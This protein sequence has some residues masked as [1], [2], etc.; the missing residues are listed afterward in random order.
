MK[1]YI[2]LIHDFLTKNTSSKQTVIKNTFWLLLAEGVS[3][4]STF[5][6]TFYVIN[7]FAISE[8]GMYSYA[9]SIWTIIAILFDYW[10]WT[11]VLRAWWDNMNVNRLLWSKT[12]FSIILFCI[13]TLI[14]IYYINIDFILAIT[15]YLSIIQFLFVSFFEFFKN[16]F[17]GIKIAYYDLT[18]RFLYSTIYL[19]LS[20]LFFYLNFPIYYIFIANILSC[21]VVIIYLVYKLIYIHW[22]VIEPHFSKNVL[23]KSIRS[24]RHLVLS[25]ALMSLYFRIDSLFIQ[26]FWWSSELW[27]YSWLYNFVLLVAIFPSFILPA[28]FPYFVEFFNK[29][30]YLKINKILFFMLIVMLVFWVIWVTFVYFFNKEILMFAYSNKL[31]LSEMSLKSFNILM[32][33]WSLILLTR[34]LIDALNATKN[35]YF[36]NISLIFA[37][38]V[39][40]ILNYYL[41]PKL[42][43]LGASYST[44]FSE[45]ILL[46][47]L[48]LFYIRRF[49][50]NLS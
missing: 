49:W 50:Y 38:W 4:W 31:F 33:S 36:N 12:L 48:L 11:S 32:L 30:S 25:S 13:L 23:L 45:F 41:V 39:N 2:T 9:L 47:F 37:L 16:I 5:L 14:F 10:Y 17:K 22:F 24:H 29:W 28:V 43:F 3:K 15:I 8:Y 7:K 19:S 27:I 44:L 1:K 34:P 21:L 18:S 26:Y 42:W 35:E 40:V 6:L 20:F 46:I